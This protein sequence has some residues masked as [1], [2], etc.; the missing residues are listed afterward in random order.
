MKK[1]YFLVLALCFFNG[2][3]AQIINFPDVAIKK[4]LLDANELQSIAL[5]LNGRNIK[6]D[7]NNNGEIEV[8]EALKVY[9][10]RI[11]L[12]N[13]YTPYL[14]NFTG[15]NKFTSLVSISF[16]NIR[17]SVIDVTELINLEELSCY[18]STVG[19]LNVSGLKKLTR[20]SCPSDYLSKIDL[21]GCTALN[22]LQ[23]NDNKLT[24]LDI[25]SCEK[26]ETLQCGGN[27]LT[28][29]D[30]DGLSNLKTLNCDR[31]K[32]SFF[33]FGYTS[34]IEKLTCS[35]NG[36]VNL[37]VSKL[38]KL[39]ELFCMKNQLV[40]LNIKGL[41]NLS[42]LDCNSNKLIS[43]D[44]KS[45]KSLYRF[46]C[47]NNELSSLLI[48][49]LP[50]LGL[51]NCRNNKL[52][53]L[54]LT[55]LVRLTI[56]SCDNNEITN[57]DFKSMNSFYNDFSLEC[58]N[59]KFSSLDLSSLKRISRLYC[60]NNPLL[61][62]INIK[63]G[64][65]HPDS[66]T[67]LE[68]SNN[69]NLNYICQDANE[70]YGV[71][72]LIK[73]YGYKNCTVNSYC[74]FIP[75][76]KLY[77]ID[78]KNKFDINNN[79]CDNLD[80]VFP[81]LNFKISNGINYDNYVYN[82]LGSCIIPVPEGNYNITPILENPEYF[83][84]SPE[85]TQINFPAQTSPY[86]Q[87]FCVISKGSH[88]DLE[89]SILPIA[90]SVPGFDSKFKIIFKNKGN[91]TQSGSVNLTF[92]DTTLDFILAIP[93]A[94]D[95]KVNSLSWNF[96]NLNPFESKEITF[97]LNVNSPMETPAVNNGDLLTF[98]ATIT[99]QVTDETPIDNAFTLNQ[100]VVGSYDPND[101]TCLEGNKIKPEL[102]GQ[103][104]HYMIRFENT[105]T[106]AAQNVVIKDMIDLSKFDISSL[107]PTSSS[108]S[109]VTKISD[110]NKVEFIFENINLPFDDAN[111]DGYVAF[112]IKTLPTL[113]VGD[114]FTNE[115][116]I[117]FDYNFPILTNKAT[118]KFE[119]TL[120]IQDFDF[121]NYF[122]LY[123]NP[124]NEELN[125]IAK[126]NIEI[127]SLTI[128]D[129]LGQ[130]V[131]AVPNAKS[132]SKIDV[133]KLS[134]GNYFVKVKSDKGISSMKFIKN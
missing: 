65:K 134:S 34:N 82:S 108:H 51:L 76:G 81:N 26:L 3:S 87:D 5:D 47:Y 104:V 46:Y 24:A 73:K 43:I 68:F 33:N 100:T 71:E 85:S 115:A 117:Y 45:L 16:Y 39:K 107:I 125:I 67:N 21:K 55:N 6:I 98:V 36:L 4:V 79:G 75:G 20:V 92:D 57:L 18:S 121:S 29:L 8:S 19:E 105:G 86:K 17:S 119:T 111:N 49:D 103:Y 102:I 132:V 66:D 127:Q 62:T 122:S 52:T 42:V 59:N 96:T 69:P 9:R 15:I 95:Q 89:I 93:V 58:S 53:S 99:S 40:S 7:T 28:T 10:L 118:S 72:V 70:I 74:S 2:L 90:P 128:Y 106:Y 133:S 83:K 54:D 31:N 123:P 56:L 130:A 84:I 110:I 77:T 88:P 112:K 35:E 129:I 113:K 41:L 38:E 23:I 94:T 12:D 120:N 1:I 116:N 63:N 91:Q 124:V 11:D 48:N 61:E 30:V 13:V 37:D 109:F 44:V 22:H 126:Q 101:K 27:L 25:I 60:Y 64:G 131:I 78:T 114:S 32:I 50:N 14:F 80:T 97:I